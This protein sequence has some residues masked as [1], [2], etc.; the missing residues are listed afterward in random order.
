M[1]SLFFLISDINP[2]FPCCSTQA[3]SQGTNVAF[4][5]GTCPLR[6]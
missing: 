2:A 6:A 3:P 5:H 1:S 4:D